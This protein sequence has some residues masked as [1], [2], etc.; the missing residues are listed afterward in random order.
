M[1]S[2]DCDWFGTI[3]TIDLKENG[4]H[5]LVNENNKKQYVKLLAFAKMGLEIQQQTEAFLLGFQEVVPSD[6]L[7]LLD[8]KDLGL[9]LSGMP[10]IDSF[11][12]FLE[13]LLIKFI[14]S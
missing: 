6:A 8:E 13:Y 1:F 2:Y 3:K 12:N 7:F 11:F 4:R 10:N 9:K 14:C 5:E